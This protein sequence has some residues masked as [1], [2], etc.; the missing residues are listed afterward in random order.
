ML[1][2]VPGCTV[3]L[4]LVLWCANRLELMVTPDDEGNPGRSAT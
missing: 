2:M 1:L 4:G 3:G